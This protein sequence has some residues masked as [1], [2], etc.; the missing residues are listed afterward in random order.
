MKKWEYLVRIIPVGP[1]SLEADTN[2]QAFL[3]ES[4]RN[5]FRLV[6]M[7][8]YEGDFVLITEKKTEE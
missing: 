6:M 1:G 7:S 8:N 4:G 3:N 5:G 2:M